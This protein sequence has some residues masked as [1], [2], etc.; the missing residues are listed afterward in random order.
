VPAWT[1]A[2][3]FSY[4]W[5][6]NGTAISGAT[7]ASYK[8]AGS[9]YQHTVAV[10]V[11]GRR[12]TYLTAS[13]TSAATPKVAGPAATITR[14]GIYRVGTQI[15]SGTYVSRGG[16]DCY[17]ERRST[18]GD[19]FEGIIS[20]D[21]GTGQR[22]VT[23][24]T[25]DRYFSTE[26]CGSWTRLVALGPARSSFGDG[27]YAVNTQLRPGLYQTT[28]SPSGCYWS[29]LSG[30]SGDLD[31]IL[32]SDYSDGQQYL[33]VTSWDVGVESSDCGTWT[34]VSG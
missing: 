21:L 26:D 24:Q 25:T 32:D 15:A 33:A 19:S 18:A 16:T 7:R 2:A 8:L 13:R 23:I 31:D 4:Q 29:V 17:W 9:D 22:I 28:G 5:L 20:N 11:T 3:T 34:R 30:F 12:A 10:R 6:R 1:P 27:V 14:D